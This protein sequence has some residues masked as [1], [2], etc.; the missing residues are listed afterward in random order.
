M[1]AKYGPWTVTADI[2]PTRSNF[3]MWKEIYAHAVEV[4]SQIYKVIVNG[5]I[6]DFLH[7]AWLFDLPLSK[8]PTFISL[9]A[10]K[11]IWI[12]DLIQPGG[13]SW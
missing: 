13:S 4:I 2:R 9:E 3:F 11:S 7:D 10:E 12:S 6:T 1:M 8:R 5:H